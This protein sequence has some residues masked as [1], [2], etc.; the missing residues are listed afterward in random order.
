MIAFSLYVGSTERWHVVAT[1]A[2]ATVNNECS[3]L[4]TTTEGL[5]LCLQLSHQHLIHKQLIH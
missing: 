4:K 5:P 1:S 2:V 3:K